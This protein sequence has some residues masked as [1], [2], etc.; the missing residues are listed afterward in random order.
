MAAPG[1][2]PLEFFENE[3]FTPLTAGKKLLLPAEF[4]DC[5]FQG[6]DLSGKDLSNRLFEE[7]T[8][9]DCNLSLARVTLAAF[10]TVT[11][12]NCKML[13]IA[14]QNASPVALS[15]TFEDCMLDNCSFF[16][17]KLRKTDFV[18][19]R[20]VQ[21]DFTETD[22]TEA[23]FEQC[24]L[25]SALFDNT[26]LE[27]ADLRTAGGYVIDPVKN[28]VDGLRVTWPEAAGLLAGFGVA[29]SAG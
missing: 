15:V 12:R 2:V 29:V 25:S 22:L 28:R 3:T 21:A 6:L 7:C 11:F 26:V 5:T 20:L 19:C 24:D 1:N 13:G 4:L 9:V 16:K 14:F 23:V 8:F 17:M 27:K 10:R 18:R